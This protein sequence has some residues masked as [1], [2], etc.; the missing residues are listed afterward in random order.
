MKT[1]QI[2]IYSGVG[3]GVLIIGYL[4]YRYYESSSSSSSSSSS[5]SSTVASSGAIAGGGGISSVNFTPS[6]E[7]TSAISSVPDL[8][9]PQIITASSIKPYSTSDINNMMSQVLEGNQDLVN[10]ASG[11]SNGSAVSSAVSTTT[12]SNSN[13]PQ[14]L[15]NLVTSGKSFPFKGTSA[16]EILMN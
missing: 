9:T 14:T 13:V 16:G 2:L 4:I 7:V 6:G 15:Q 11:I 8:S 12:S 5:P 10:T 3:V 1:K